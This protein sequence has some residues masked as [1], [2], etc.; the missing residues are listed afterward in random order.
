MSAIYYQRAVEL[1]GQ[2][3]SLSEPQLYNLK[4]KEY[5]WS[6]YIRNALLGSKTEVENTFKRGLSCEGHHV[7]VVAPVVRGR[8]NG[9]SLL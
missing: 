3:L 4:I 9:V 7:E 2:F 1:W 8:M 5:I 6:K